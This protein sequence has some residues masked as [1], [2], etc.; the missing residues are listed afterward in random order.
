MAK[1]KFKKPLRKKETKYKP[2]DGDKRDVQD[3]EVSLSSSYSTNYETEQTS[4][5]KVII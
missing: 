5:Q 4:D 3:E 2:G 1:V